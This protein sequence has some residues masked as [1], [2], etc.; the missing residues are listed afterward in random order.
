MKCGHPG[1]ASLSVFFT[2]L[3]T[4]CSSGFRAIRHTSGYGRCRTSQSLTTL[5]HM[6]SYALSSVCPRYASIFIVLVM[7]C[8]NAQVTVFDPAPGLD[9]RTPV[10]RIRFYETQRPTCAYMELGRI[11]ASGDMFSSWGR[12]VHK[13]REKAHDLGG[14]AVLSLHEGRRVT[15]AVLSRTQVSTTEDRSLSGIVIRFTNPSCRE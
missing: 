12:V 9:R 4:P 15:G 8:V 5:E 13:V 1:S 7:G 14:D 3:S 6:S 10:D 2:T 11:T